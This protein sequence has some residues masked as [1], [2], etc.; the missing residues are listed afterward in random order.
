MTASCVHG[1]HTTEMTHPQAV[2]WKNGV[3][4][5]QGTCADCGTTTSKIVGTA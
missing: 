2:V 5:V 1:K 3:E 4:A